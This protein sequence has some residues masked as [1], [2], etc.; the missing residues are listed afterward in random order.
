[1]SLQYRCAGSEKKEQ[2]ITLGRYYRHMHR[3]CKSLIAEFLVYI[4]F[5]LQFYPAVFALFQSSTALESQE[6]SGSP[7]ANDRIHDSRL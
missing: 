5:N 1:M 7:A 3:I 4:D 6:F 2:C